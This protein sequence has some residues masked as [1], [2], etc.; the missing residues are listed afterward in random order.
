[1][2]LKRLHPQYITNEQ[3]NKTAVILSIDSFEELLEDIDRFGYYR[4][5]KRRTNHLS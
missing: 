1:M 4:R 2:D 3:G 5:T